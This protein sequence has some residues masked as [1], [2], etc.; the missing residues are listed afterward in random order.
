[1]FWLI[2]R[3]KLSAHAWI[4]VAPNANHSSVNTVIFY[5]AA[6]VQNGGRVCLPGMWG[7]SVVCSLQRVCVVL[8]CNT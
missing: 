1:M 2:T 5:L 4:Q 6:F 8:F 3:S 7:I